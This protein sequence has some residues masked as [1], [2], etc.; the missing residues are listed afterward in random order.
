MLDVRPF[1]IAVPDQEIADLKQRLR[2]TR[3]PLKEITSDAKG[4]EYGLTMARLKE[5]ASKWE[6]VFDW[7]SVE[8]EFN[9]QGLPTPDFGSCLS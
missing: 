4:L 9:R 2:N 7:K 8:A 5:L 6:N 1:T 3:W